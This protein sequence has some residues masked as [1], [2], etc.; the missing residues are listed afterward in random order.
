MSQQVTLKLTD[1]TLTQVNSTVEVTRTVPEVVISGISGPAGPTWAGKYGSFYSTATQ[2]PAQINVAQAIPFN[3]THTS[4]GIS[5]TSDSRITLPTVGTYTMTV[6]A[7]LSN[8]SNSTETARF[9]LRLN[10]NDYPYSTTT[11]A[12]PKEKSAG[13]PHDSLVTLTFVGTSTLTNDYVEV[14]WQSSSTSLTLKAEGVSTSP[15]YPASPS[16]IVGIAQ[17][18]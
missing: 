13:V 5:I 8:L 9:W 11:C 2:T 17:I 6:V 12:V 1:V 18:A 16:V 10:G 14:F 4:S 3:A 7:Q 15:P